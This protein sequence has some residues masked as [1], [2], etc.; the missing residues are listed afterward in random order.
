MDGIT[1]RKSIDRTY[2]MIASGTPAQ[3]AVSEYY[4]KDPP[5]ERAAKQTVDLE[6]KAD[7]PVV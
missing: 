5:N 3:V 6:V 2:S 7:L 4:R 1:Q